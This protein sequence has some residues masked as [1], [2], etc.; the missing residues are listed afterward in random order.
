VSSEPGAAVPSQISDGFLTRIY[1]V[2]RRP[3]A[4]F[5][6]MLAAPTWVGLLAALT[7]ATAASRIALFET[8]IGRRA[9]VDD[10]ERTAIAFG[11]EVDDARYEELKA[12]SAHGFAYGL[13]T[14]VMSGPL[15]VFAVTGLVVLVFGRSQ[16]RQVCAVATLASV[17]LALRQIVGAVTSYASES[18]A[19]AMS[20]GTWFSGLDEVSPLA[21]FV[22]ALDLFVIW[23][24]V[25]LAIGVGV[26]YQRNA[27]RLALT[28]LGAY[29]GL[30]LVLA[31]TIAALGGTTS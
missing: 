3:R 17:P 6:A 7:V 1:G 21:R 16:F 11:Q 26:L 25:V 31:G 4:T 28:F 9:L 8:E 18:T 27:R 5:T 14:A 13:S 30:A 10:W 12:L 23:W 19:N 22:G 24:L 15:L 20:I 2:V 29:A